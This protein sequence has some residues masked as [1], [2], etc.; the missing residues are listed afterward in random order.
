M[1]KK[2]HH[3][4]SWVTW[5]SSIENFKVKGRNDGTRVQQWLS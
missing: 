5:D 1:R 4:E 2:K 3:M